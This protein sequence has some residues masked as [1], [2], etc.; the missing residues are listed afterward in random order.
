MG[1]RLSTS[2]AGSGSSISLGFV[3]I[4]VIRLVYILTPALDF[5]NY[6]LPVW[7]GWFDVPVG[8]ASNQRPALSFLPCALTALPFT[9]EEHLHRSV[10]F[11]EG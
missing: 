1:S 10:T 11:P 7:M 3:G 4:E 2:H 8:R 9:P 6:Q 5:L